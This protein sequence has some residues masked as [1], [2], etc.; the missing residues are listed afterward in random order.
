MSFPG[1]NPTEYDHLRS[2]WS[3]SKPA[4]RASIAKY[5]DPHRTVPHSV[6]AEQGVLGSILIS[7]RETIAECVE[8]IDD[9]FFYVPAHRSIYMVLVDLWSAGQLI[10]LITFTQVLRDRNLLDS[11]GGASATVSAPV[12]SF[13]PDGRRG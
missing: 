1:T 8:K 4:S 9:E 11:V 5:A 3:G 12:A 13:A 7:P 6:E 2:T 10:D